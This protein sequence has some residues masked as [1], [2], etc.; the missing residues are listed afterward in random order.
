MR[1]NNKYIGCNYTGFS[2][3]GGINSSFNN[4]FKDEEVLIGSG[5]DSIIFLVLWEI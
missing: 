5:L 2:Y 3:I 1:V 4:T